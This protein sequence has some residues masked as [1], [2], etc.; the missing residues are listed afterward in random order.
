MTDS[1][2]NLLDHKSCNASNVTCRRIVYCGL[3]YC[4]LMDNY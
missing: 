3:S 4:I 1:S 2:L